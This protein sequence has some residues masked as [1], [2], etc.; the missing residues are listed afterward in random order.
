MLNFIDSIVT[1]YFF[2]AYG[3]FLGPTQQ[4]INNPFGIGWISIA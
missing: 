4:H 2:L 1:V 3:V